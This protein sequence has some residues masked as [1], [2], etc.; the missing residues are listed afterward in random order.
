M[1]GLYFYLSPLLNMV[2]VSFE[3]RM[4]KLVMERVNKLY[5][6]SLT[7]IPPPIT[8]PVASSV[9]LITHPKDRSDSNEMRL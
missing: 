4:E 5:E 2:I 1:L 9:A 8:S 3:L 7:V 6:L